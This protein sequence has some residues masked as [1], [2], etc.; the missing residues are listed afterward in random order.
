LKGRIGR[1]LRAYGRDLALAGV[2]AALGIALVIVQIVNEPDPAPVSRTAE[3]TPER[4]ATRPAGP[5][6]PGVAGLPQ[7]DRPPAIQRETAPNS[8]VREKAPAARTPQAAATWQ[9]HAAV[10]PPPGNRPMIALII[11]DMGVDRKRTAQAIEL[12]G[13]LTMSFLSYAEDLPDQTAAAR[14]A[15]HE[16]MVHVPMEPEGEV[17]EPGPNV[18]RTD[19]PQ[20]EV[21]KRLDWALGRFDGFVGINNHMGSRYTADA[22][23]MTLVL[24]EIRRR[25]LLFVDSRTTPHSVARRLSRKLSVPFAERDVFID[26]DPRPQAILRQLDEIVR[27]ARDRKYAVAIGHP[28]DATLAAL[29]KWLP[30]LRLRGLVLVPVSAIVRHRTKAE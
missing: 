22:D 14:K 4:S 12:D 25:G 7:K 29:R 3:T 28:R 13:P 17:A 26:D 16:L 10:H 5:E 15:G 6:P 23:G 21:R 11:D 30:T 19:Q 8:S 24:E 20:A 18:I 9:L 2:G 27:R 1:F